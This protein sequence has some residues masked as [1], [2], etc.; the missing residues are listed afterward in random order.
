MNKTQTLLRTVLLRQ[1]EVECA[2][3]VALV[4]TVVRKGNADK[5]T[6]ALTARDYRPLARMPK[7][8]K[9]GNYA[10]PSDLQPIIGGSVVAVRWAKGYSQWYPQFA[11]DGEHVRR[12]DEV[13]GDYTEA[14]R[15]IRQA[16]G[17][18]LI[19]VA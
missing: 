15:L 7:G 12:R 10:V 14:Y 17:E 1:T 3:A 13:T 6:A 18:G 8:S 4:P 9:T 19:P 5:A 16:F 2:N 11:V